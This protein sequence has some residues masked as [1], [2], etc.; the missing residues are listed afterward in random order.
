MTASPFPETLG[1]GNRSCQNWLSC[2]PVVQ[3]GGKFLSRGISSAWILLEAFQANR[4]EVWINARIDRPRCLRFLLDDLSQ[5]LDGGFGLEGR[6]LRQQGIED[7][8][9]SVDVRDGG[10]RLAMSLCLFGGHVIGGARD[11]GG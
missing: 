7:R 1:D 5:C 3:V 10:D 9:E 2:Q 4:L 6:P 11:A 8:A